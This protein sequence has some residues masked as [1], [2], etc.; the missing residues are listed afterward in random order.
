MG[1][2]FQ[3]TVDVGGGSKVQHQ[4]GLGGRVRGETG[5][6]RPGGRSLTA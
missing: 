5:R 3:E 4:D 2:G 6:I 1:A